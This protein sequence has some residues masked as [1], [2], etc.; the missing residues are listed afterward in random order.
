VQAAE[1]LIAP[2]GT[3]GWGS[4]PASA[5]NYDPIEVRNQI[6]DYKARAAVII[7]ANA[8]ALLQNAVQSGN[9]SYDLMGAAQAIYVQAR[10]E[11]AHTN[12]IM[13]QLTMFEQQVTSTFGEIVFQS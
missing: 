9:G 7:N 12:Y 3:V 2:S 5:F 11:T 10:D 4:L 8:T 13:Q 1:K 6:Y